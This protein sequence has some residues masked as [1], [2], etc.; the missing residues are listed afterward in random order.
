MSRITRRT[1]VL[2][3]AA[4]A[5]LLLG[6]AG[7]AL[8][9]PNGD[10]GNPPPPINQAPSASL[11]VS[12][13]PALVNN[14]VLVSARAAKV[15][16]LEDT[17]FGR[18]AV[19]FDAS[20]SSDPDGSIS[21]YEWDLDG[22]GTFE[23]STTTP[24]TSRSYETPGVLQVRVRVTDNGNKKDVA[25]KSLRIHRAP[26][27]VIKATPTDITVGQKTTLSAVGSTDEDGI[28]KY[29]W[30][31][32]GNGSFETNTAASPT[33]QAPFAT[34]GAKTVRVRVTDIYNAS[35]SAA[36]TVTAH[37]APVAAYTAAPNPAVTGERV[38]FDASDSLVTEPVVK[39]E[40][41]L[42]GNGTFETDTGASP[43]AARAYTAPGTVATQL[44]ITDRQGSQD[45]ETRNVR[46]LTPAQV[47][48]DRTAPVVRITA[49]SSRIS[50]TGRVTLTVACPVSERL[51]TGRVALRKSGAS[52]AAVG[53]RA[54]T[55]GGGQKAQVR[56]LLSRSAQKTVK[57]NGRLA[58]R[59]TASARDAAGNKGTS[60]RRLTVRKA[61][62]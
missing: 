24:K 43:K 21:K 42:D 61:A 41:D 45:V 26:K 28:A 31:L 36:T 29:E 48:V 55:L 4:A 62:R 37:P 44:R 52:S 57:R 3:P 18:N 25:I 23:K 17:V 38:S 46:V 14:P 10:P 6:T 59:I 50:K 20:A 2:V 54:F 7:N 33:V 34:V 56:V 60:T 47:P 35:G 40:W 16:G 5:A 15:T 39:F 12:P 49:P 27:A 51:C 13:N 11:T 19:T 22:N 1:A 53:S 8:A 9:I 32:D 58:V 30:D